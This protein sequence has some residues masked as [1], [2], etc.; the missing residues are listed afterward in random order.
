MFLFTI[1]TDVVE[2]HYFHG[3]SSFMVTFGGYAGLLCI[4][5]FQFCLC[6]F[7]CDQLYKFS[8]KQ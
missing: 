7:L 1:N 6:F 8:S 2:F 3:T 5:H 4:P